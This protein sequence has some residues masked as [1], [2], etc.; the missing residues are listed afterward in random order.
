MNPAKIAHRLREVMCGEVHSVISDHSADLGDP[1]GG[2]ERFGSV[3]ELHRSGGLSSG[4]TA[5]WASRVYSSTAEYGYVYPPA[6]R[7][8]FFAASLVR[9]AARVASESRVWAKQPPP[10]G[11]RPTFFTS[12]WTIASGARAVMTPSCRFEDL[13]GSRW[14][15]LL[16]PRCLNQRPTVLG[17]IWK[18]WS[19]PSSNA[20]RAAA[21]LCSLRQD[22]I[23]PTTQFGVEAEEACGPEDR[24]CRP[25]SPWGW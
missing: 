16:M 10:S 6:F 9:L 4:I 5:V 3:E 15:R 2:E 18:P 17:W 12:T 13:S 22:S 25:F 1:L 21:H 19:R 23:R 7:L 8:C 24:S 14:R 20:I 11:M